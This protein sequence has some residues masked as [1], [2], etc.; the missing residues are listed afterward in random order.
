LLTE[1][2]PD[3]HFTI[4]AA[5]AHFFAGAF[6]KETGPGKDVDYASL[7]ATFRF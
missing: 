4:T 2:R 3:R 1:W 6:L 7:W 5:Y